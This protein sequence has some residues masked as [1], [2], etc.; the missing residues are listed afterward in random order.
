MAASCPALFDDYLLCSVCQDV[1]RDPVL[2]LCTHSFCRTCLQQYW[3]H[4]ESPTCP[5]C[6]TNSSIDNPPCNLA[7]KNLC[8]AFIREK[9]QKTSAESEVLC[10]LHGK[11][12]THYCVEEKQPVCEECRTSEIHANHQFKL[13]DEAAVDLKSDLKR[14]LAPLKEKLTFF[15]NIKFTFVTTEEYIKSQAY[16]TEARIRSEFEKL[17]QFLWDEETNRIAELRKEEKR[18][19]QTVMKK[20]TQINRDIASLIELCTGIEKEIEGNNISFLQNYEATVKRTQCELKNPEIISDSL[21]D[22]AKHLGNLKFRLWEKMQ[23]IIHYSPVILNPNTAHPYLHLSNDLTEVKLRT[24]NPDIP[25]NLERFDDYSSVLGSVG[26]DSGTHSWDVEVGDSTAW[27]V[28]VIS[29]SAYKHR[30]NL[31][32]PGLWHVGYYKGKYGNGLS[33]KMLIPL[34]LQDKL[35]RIRVILDW[36][37]GRVSFY[38][39]VGNTHVH[40]FEHMFTERVYPYFC[41]V[42]PAN[43]LR[44]VPVEIALTEEWCEK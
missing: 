22:V 21:I 27:A 44:I 32:K 17:H 39:P 38:N 31:S 14:K 41:N 2:L 40:T 15:K 7:L 1:F 9:Q 6:R 33:D 10:G 36:D 18:R 42:C 12:L 26:Y 16:S 35:Q 23:S 4:T 43:T 30:K 28:G 29:E 8:E 25:A 24:R 20:R 13:L 5:L 3:Q 34:R 11:K 37:G 19:S